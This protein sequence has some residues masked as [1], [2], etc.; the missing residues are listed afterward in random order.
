MGILS[1]KVEPKGSEFSPESPEI[2]HDWFYYDSQH[3]NFSLLELV[4]ISDK[5]CIV[6]FSLN[7]LLTWASKYI[8]IYI[9]N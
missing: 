5:T 4:G 7:Y 6:C 3:G 9:N 8:Y 2:L 1:R